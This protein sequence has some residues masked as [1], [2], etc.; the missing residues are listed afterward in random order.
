MFRVM[1]AP[2]LAVDGQMRAAREV[3][4]SED[5]TRILRP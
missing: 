4:T 1:A 5:G 2:A 3:L